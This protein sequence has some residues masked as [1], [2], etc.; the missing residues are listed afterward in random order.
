DWAIM[1][2]ALFASIAPVLHPNLFVIGG[3]LTEMSESARAWFLQVVQRVYD[4]TNAQRCFNSEPGNCEIV[5]SASTDQGWRG[6]VLMG[7]RA[8]GA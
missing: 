4:E 3:G 1:I 2:G 7:M 8:R 5:W 6:A